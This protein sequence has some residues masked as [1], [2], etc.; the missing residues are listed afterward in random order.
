MKGDRGVPLVR[1]GNLFLW[2]FSGSPEQMTVPGRAALVNAITYMKKFDG[3]I[4]TRRVGT[5]E[6]STWQGILDS[7]YVRPDRLPTYFGP[8][9][10]AAHGKD[11]EAYRADLEQR[12]PFLYVARGTAALSIDSDA[13]ALGYPTDSLDLIKAALLS[14]D[15]RGRRVMERYWPSDDL[16]IA[17]PKTV[18]ELEKVANQVVFSE[19]HGY[20]WLSKPPM[21]APQRWEIVDALKAMDLSETLRVCSGNFRR[22]TRR[23]LQR[24]ESGLRHEAWLGNA[25]CPSDGP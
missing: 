19:T 14:A 25:C 9:L 18:E 20:R 6:R 22:P 16:V 8:S 12:S 23:R 7:P 24:E 11:K 4:P 2:G 21:A 13:E 10:V 15:E 17:R 3:K 1:E 5:R